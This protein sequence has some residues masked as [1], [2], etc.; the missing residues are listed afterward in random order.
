LYKDIALSQLSEE[1]ILCQDQWEGK[2]SRLQK[3]K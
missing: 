2:M 3:K 1:E